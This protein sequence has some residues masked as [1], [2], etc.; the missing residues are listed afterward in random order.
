MRLSV[1]SGKSNTQSNC[2]CQAIT[3][4][5]KNEK[6]IADRQV[7]SKEKKTREVNYN[8]K[9]K[10]IAKFDQCSIENRSTG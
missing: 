2:I 4:G 10:A 8:E 1:E 6:Q 9:Y 5:R 3:E 7:R